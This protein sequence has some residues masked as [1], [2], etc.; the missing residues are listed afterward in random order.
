[1]FHGLLIHLDEM[2]ICLLLEPE[3][4]DFVFSNRKSK[5]EL[6]LSEGNPPKWC[7]QLCRSSCATRSLCAYWMDCE[8]NVSMSK[9]YQKS[10]LKHLE[11]DPFAR[12]SWMSFRVKIDPAPPSLMISNECVSLGSK[13]LL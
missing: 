7:Q 1:M 10:E 12:N 13:P 4:F 3:G 9:L 6:R 11:K 5:Q 8:R 2:V